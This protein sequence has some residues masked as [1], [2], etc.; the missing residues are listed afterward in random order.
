MSYVTCAY[1]NG[2]ISEC[3]RPVSINVGVDHQLD[4]PYA[5][6]W[7]NDYCTYSSG[8]WGYVNPT[9]TLWPS[10]VDNGGPLVTN[11]LSWYHSLNHADVHPHFRLDP[12]DVGSP[13]CVTYF[14][15]IGDGSMLKNFRCATTAT[16]A[17][18][19][20]TYTNGPVMASACRTATLV[21]S[22]SSTAPTLAP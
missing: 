10:C 17:S 9:S 14:L 1:E 7:T 22:I 11:H 5:C 18:Y 3:Y 2:D 15:N 6:P 16:S 21:S 8:P 20:N 4:L 12:S 19:L 13:A